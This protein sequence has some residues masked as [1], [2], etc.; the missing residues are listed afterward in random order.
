MEAQGTLNSQNNLGKLRMKLVEDSHFL[1]PKLTTK[2]Q[3]SK[4]WYWHQDRHTDQL[5]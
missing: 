5:V 4:L 2:L 3:L 1:I